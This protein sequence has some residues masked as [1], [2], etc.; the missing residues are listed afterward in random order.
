MT[1]VPYADKKFATINGVRMAYL[2][3]GDGPPIVFRHGN[4]T[5]SYLWRNVMP[6]LA[7]LGRRPPIWSTRHSRRRARA[8]RSKP[9]RPASHRDNRSGLGRAVCQLSSNQ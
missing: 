5:S 2:D 4:P 9:R 1:T 3:T 6:H 8:Q 7:G